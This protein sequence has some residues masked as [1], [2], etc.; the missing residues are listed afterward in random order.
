VTDF[1]GD[2]QED[3]FLSQNFFAFRVEDS[4]LDAGRGLLLQGD[5]G[6]NFTPVPGQFSGIKVYGEQRGAST[7]DFDGDR[8]VDLVVAQNGATTKLYRNRGGRP[9]FRVRLAGPAANPD[10]IGAVV[11]LRFGD[12]WGSARELHAGSGWWSQEGAVPIL[13]ATQAVTAVWVR[14]PGAKTTE[15]QVPVGATE[16]TVSWTNGPN[17]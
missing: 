11:R 9:G 7:A 1:D 2:G 14:W 16:A 17:P 3:I 4:R 10:A 6:G 8:R 13:G 12:Q 15:Q 5:G